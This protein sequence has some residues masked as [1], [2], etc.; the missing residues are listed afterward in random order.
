MVQR[1]VALSPFQERIRAAGLRVTPARE[2]L[3]AA[4]A[5]HGHAT[6][7]RLHQLVALQLPGLSL[8][9]VYRTLESMAD[10]GLIGHTHLAAHQK[11]Y[12]LTSDE[13]RAHLVC[14]RC[15]SVTEMDPDVAGSFLKALGSTHA[16]RADGS[17]LSVFGTCAACVVA[18]E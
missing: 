3:L 2:L 10:H 13:D 7:E 17:H 12:T 14:R 18:P 9:T 5:V 6:P 4:V 1:S 11:S 15:D 8:S 16:F